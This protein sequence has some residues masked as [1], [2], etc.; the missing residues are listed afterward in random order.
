VT[1]PRQLFVYGASGHGKVVADAARLSGEF[2]VV[3]FIDDAP[4][5]RLKPFCGLH[6]VGGRASVAGL[7]EGALI[8][9]AVGSN[10]DRKR[11]V[12]DL[13]IEARRIV[14][15][16]HPAASVSP[17]AVLGCGT[18]VG[19]GATI[20]VD[21]RVGRGCIVNSGAIVEHDDLLGDFAH[22]SPSATLGGGVRVG[23]GAHVGLGACALPGVTI[24]RWACIGAGAVVIR[25]I[26]SYVTAA[27][28]PARVLRNLSGGDHERKSA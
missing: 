22:L 2:E 15:V 16:V 20:H 1:A 8:A 24:G 18:F 28:V 6:V 3:G 17:G 27:G 26:P 25:S 13:G 23:E 7:P 21:A 14:T 19:P 4:E 11:I 5:K 10:A 9:L 12:R